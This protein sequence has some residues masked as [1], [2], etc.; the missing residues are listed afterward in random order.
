MGWMES[1]DWWEGR[2]CKDD[3]DTSDRREL[4]VGCPC[5]LVWVGEWS[6]WL[7]PLMPTTSYKVLSKQL[8]N[9]MQMMKKGKE[10]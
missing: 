10:E 2:E 9:L 8:L 6:V 5:V 1:H 3:T 7:S 4:L